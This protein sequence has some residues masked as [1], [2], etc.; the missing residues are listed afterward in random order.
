MRIPM[1]A[2][3]AKFMTNY[4]EDIY[5]VSIWMKLV[6]ARRVEVGV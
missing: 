4:E 5:D 3:N 6:G 2:R 1:M